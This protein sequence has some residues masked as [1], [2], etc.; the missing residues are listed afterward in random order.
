AATVAINL[1][2]PWME[3]LS[4]FERTTSTIVIVAAAG[5]GVFLAGRRVVRSL[6]CLTVELSSHPLGAGESV[7]V[8][9]SHPD[10][11]ALQGVELE[12][13]CVER[14]GAGKSE[15]TNTLYKGQIS[16]QKSIAADS[17]RSGEVAVPAGL[18]ATFKLQQQEIQWQI[19]AFMVVGMRWKIAFP[20]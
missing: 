18:P 7:S 10:A 14:S 5:A 9:V 20:I 4:R 11:K 13:I 15:K 19:V 8:R 12:L 2:K 16:L 1:L 3:Q 6:L 17:E